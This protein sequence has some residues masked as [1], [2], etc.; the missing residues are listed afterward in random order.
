MC[1]LEISVCSHF[2]VNNYKHVQTY[3]H[4]KGKRGGRGKTLKQWLNE[5]LNSNPK[6]M[7]KKTYRARIISIIPAL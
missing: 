5:N 3:L 4:L 1:L 7:H 2:D 6:N